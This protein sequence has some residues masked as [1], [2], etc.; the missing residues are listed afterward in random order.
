MKTFVY[1]AVVVCAFWVGAILANAELSG[2]SSI[3]A[4]ADMDETTSSNGE[5]IN[6]CSRAVLKH[7]LELCESISMADEDGNLEELHTYCRESLER[8][9]DYCLKHAEQ[10]VA[11]VVAD[12]KFV[13]ELGKAV[14]VNNEQ[15]AEL[16][17][18]GG[19]RATRTHLEQFIA[20]L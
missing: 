9:A 5:P 15:Q 13:D 14:G 20:G 4:E 2:E 8:V 3:N 11:K 16:A 7:R 12:Q 18:N 6:D 17:V 10:V 19:S 1:V